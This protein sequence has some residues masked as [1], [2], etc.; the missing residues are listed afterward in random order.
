MKSSK[1]EVTRQKG[2]RKYTIELLDGSKVYADKWSSRVGGIWPAM[3]TTMMTEASD[4]IFER[5]GGETTQHKKM[6]IPVS[7]VLV[8]Y[9]SKDIY[10]HSC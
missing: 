5:K 9:E 2:E 1:N 4:A 3:T 10:E 6:Y 8:G 7:S